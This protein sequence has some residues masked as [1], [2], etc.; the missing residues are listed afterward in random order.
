MYSSRR[1]TMGG[2]RSPTSTSSRSILFRKYTSV[3]MT[4]DEAEDGSPLLIDNHASEVVDPVWDLYAH[5]VERAGA[6]PTLIE[7]DNNVPDWPVL[8]A[9]ARRAEKIMQSTEDSPAA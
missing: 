7:W 3:A 8:E 1:R 4:G 5:A 2:A 6:L 9:E